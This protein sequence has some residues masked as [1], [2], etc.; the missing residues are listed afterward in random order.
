MQIFIRGLNQNLLTVDV[1]DLGENPTLF[2][3]FH[4][5]EDRCPEGNMFHRYVPIP[6]SGVC[7]IKQN[8]KVTQPLT[9]FI[10][11]FIQLT[12]Y[13]AFG[14]PRYVVDNHITTVEILEK[15]EYCTNGVF[16]AKF[17][18][19]V[20][21]QTDDIKL[22]NFIFELYLVDFRDP[23]RYLLLNKN[24]HCTA[25]KHNVNLN[26]T[27]KCNYDFTNNSNNNPK[28]LFVI[29]YNNSDDSLSDVKVD[30]CS[31]CKP[32]TLILEKE[33]I[34]NNIRMLTQIHFRYDQQT[35]NLQ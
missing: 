9:N 7:D 17:K 11:N 22:Q 8:F 31:G 35:N 16:K 30:C 15:L 4:Y 23:D 24:A 34:P 27:V 3:L 5:I 13:F 19:D 1:K 6:N 26:L 2:T 21:N 32:S 18:T 33:K 29:K 14:S 20:I 25:A 28:Y 10:Q 12:W